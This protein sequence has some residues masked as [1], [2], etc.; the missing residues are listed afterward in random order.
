MTDSMKK[1][2]VKFG[3]MNIFSKE[4][5]Q[6]VTGASSGGI[7][8]KSQKEQD[9]YAKRAYEE[10]RKKNADSD[11]AKVAKSSG[12]TKEEVAKVRN[13]LF[14]AE[15][16]LEKGL[17]RFDESAEIANAWE[18]LE[19]GRA[20]ELDIMLIKHELEELTIMEQYGYP[21][22]K[23]HLLANRKYPWEFKKKGGWTDD[24]IQIEIDRQLKDLL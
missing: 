21:Y 3:L 7:L 23:A 6:V 18:A 15:H 16:N 1:Q 19:Q 8:D 9:A 5:S 2:A 12:L 4:R 17:S 10:I 22:E 20:K 11:I 24:S 14:F 13:H